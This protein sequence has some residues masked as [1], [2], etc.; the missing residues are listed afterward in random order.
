MKGQP[1]ALSAKTFLM[2]WLATLAA[3]FMLLYSR[4]EIGMPSPSPAKAG[5]AGGGAAARQPQILNP[6]LL[7][8]KAAGAAPREYVPLDLSP[9]PGK[10]LEVLALAKMRPKAA[11]AVID[12][13][14]EED[15]IYVLAQMNGREAAYILESLAPDAA[16]RLLT[17]LITAT[18]A[19]EQAQANAAAVG[20]GAATGAAG[21]AGT[22][23][24]GGTPATPPGG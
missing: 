1:D 21:A 12:T 6:S 20:G 9:L 23:P 10:P 22:P 14:T 4:G 11:G 3:V 13:L 17:A 8:S 16:T 19:K 15:A 7:A 24:A 18:R 5:G 2:L